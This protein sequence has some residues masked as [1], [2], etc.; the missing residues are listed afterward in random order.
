[1]MVTGEEIVGALHIDPD[2]KCKLQPETSE[3]LWSFDYQ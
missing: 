2:R 3:S 1:M